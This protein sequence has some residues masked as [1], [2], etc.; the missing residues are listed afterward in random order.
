VVV[1]LVCFIVLS[2]MLLFKNRRLFHDPIHEDGDFAANSILIEDAKHFDLLVGHY[3]REI[4][5]HPG[6]A[7]LY[8]QAGGEVLFHDILAVAPTAYDGQAISVLF[9]YAALLAVALMIVYDVTAR[10]SAVVAAAACIMAFSSA[11]ALVLASNWIPY[12]LFAP[13]FLLLIAAASVAVGNSRHL[14]CL[15]LA[16]GL[17]VHGHV[18]FLFFVPAV[19]ILAVLGLVLIG[20][21]G[22]ADS[23]RDW[24]A[25][26]G[27]VA[28]FLLPILLNFVLNFP[29]E[30]GKYWGYSQSDTAGGHSLHEAVT[31]VFGFWWRGPGGYAVAALVCGVAAAVSARHPIIGVRRFLGSALAAVALATALFVFYAARGIDDVS[32][33]YIGFF[34]WAAPMT[35]L[36]VAAIAVVGLVRGARLSRVAMVVGAVVLVLSLRGSGLV[37]IYEGLPQLPETVRTLAATRSDPQQTIV[38]DFDHDAWPEAV[39]VLVEAQRQGVRACVL[40]ASWAFMVTDRFVCSASEA[41]SVRRQFFPAPAP[42]VWRPQP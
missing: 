22:F 17:L 32:E 20:R 25:F 24:A 33:R 29:G 6:P 40:D 2:G 37:N 39:G 7:A 28:V 5:N 23:R 30:F 27:V 19:A 9:L 26:G 13:F 12:Y 16:G 10:A 8:L 36:V 41:I 11:H 4:F 31:Y 38:L 21:V 1:F 18:E 15:A 42:H 35:V 3:S 14:W 34:Y